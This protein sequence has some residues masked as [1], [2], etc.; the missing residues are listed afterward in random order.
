MKKVLV[1]GANGY[2][3]RH[4]VETL[5]NHG[6]E[7][8]ACDFRFDGVDERAN[9]IYTPIFNGE[10]DI[11]E[12]LG[13]PDI[14]IHMAWR[15][16]FVHNSQ[17]HI[18]DLYNHY[19]FL[20]NM[21]SGGLKHLSVMGTMHEVGYW[22][23]AIDENSPTNPSSLYGIAK[24]SLRQALELLTKDDEIVLQWLRGY[25]IIGDD[26]KSNSIFSK[27]TKAEMEGKANFPFTTGKNKYDFISIEGLAE[28]IVATSTQSEIKG[29]INC[30]SGNPISLAQRVEEFIKENNFKIKLE[31]GV[32]PDRKYDSPAVWGDNT[33]IQSILGATAKK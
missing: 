7:V 31:Y 28:Q 5:L 10:E 30:C 8:D 20:S 24:N 11:Y 27:I 22:E 33:K 23:G 21:I 16:G 29:I 26:L 12:K 13:K 18:E 17:T 15:N 1:T 25:Y 9:K 4:I 2:I 3:G 19:T 6:Y 14:C 32:F